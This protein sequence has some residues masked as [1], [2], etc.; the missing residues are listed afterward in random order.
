MA[1]DGAEDHHSG[2]AARRSRLVVAER[3]RILDSIGL[4]SDQSPSLS[5]RGIRL[6]QDGLAPLEPRHK[7]GGSG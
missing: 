6:R 4:A 3:G 2:L 5:L 1:S 7:T